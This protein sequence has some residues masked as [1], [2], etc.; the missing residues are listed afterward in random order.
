PGR[1]RTTP[2]AGDRGKGSR[3]PSAGAATPPSSP[4]IRHEPV[5]PLRLLP[6]L[7]ASAAAGIPA[8]H[9]NFDGAS[10]AERLAESYGR[11]ELDAAQ[12]AGASSWQPRDGF[13]DTLANGSSTAHLVVPSPLSPGAGGFTVTLW[14]HRTTGSG[15]IS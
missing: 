1:R 8:A 2:S 14:S 6:L 11:T 4:E 9:W 13:G 10:A 7:A 12:Q 5:N 15:S 3:F